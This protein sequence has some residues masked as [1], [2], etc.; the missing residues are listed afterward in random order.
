MTGL[1][2]GLTAGIVLLTGRFF[3]GGGNRQTMTTSYRAS[4]STRWHFAFGAIRI[5]SV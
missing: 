5:G 2:T 3:L 4:I 1:P